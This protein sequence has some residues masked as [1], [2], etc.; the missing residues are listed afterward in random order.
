MFTSHPHADTELDDL[1]AKLESLSVEINIIKTDLRLALQQTGAQAKSSSKGPN[2]PNVGF[3]CDPESPS[4]GFT[5]L[6]SK[7]LNM[8][9]EWYP[10][11]CDDIL[12]YYGNFEI[13]GNGR[14][15][16]GYYLIQQNA[17]ETSRVYMKCTSS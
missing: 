2:D 17:S 10:S 14:M 5:C 11:S 3:V 16:V 9:L 1:K 15:P 4:T 7:T 13:G 12:Y 8:R 6:H